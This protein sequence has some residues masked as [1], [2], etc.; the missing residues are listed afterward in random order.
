PFNPSTKIKYSIPQL[1]NVVIKV[2]DILGNE[3]ETLVNEEKSAGTYEVI[4]SASQLPSGVYFY[5]LKAGDFIST[6]KMI[7]LK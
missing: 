6:K 7:L 3:I 2:F 5:Q 1:S 4:W